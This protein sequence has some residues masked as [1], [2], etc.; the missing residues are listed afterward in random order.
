MSNTLPAQRL[1]TVMTRDVVSINMDLTLGQAM[2][3]CSEKL[4]RHLLV[5]DEEK[6]LVGVV[7]DRDLRYY[8][9]PR[10]GTLSENNADRATLSR[11]IHQIMA[12]QV[13]SATVD[14]T[15]S[16]AAQLMLTNGVGCLPVVDA[17]RRVLGII[18]TVDFLRFIA[19]AD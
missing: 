2:E 3:L 8:I 16:E 19:K 6:R 13:V 14:I 12:R 1:D 10:M 4:I 18:T 17:D 11:H 5:V 9:S 15:L 7:T